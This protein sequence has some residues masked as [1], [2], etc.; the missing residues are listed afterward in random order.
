[1][2]QLSEVRDTSDELAR[3]GVVVFGVN[4][5]GAKSHEDF[6]V[7]YGYGFPLLVD[8]GGKVATAYGARMGSGTGR[9]VYLIDRDRR[10]AF[11]EKGFPPISDVLAALP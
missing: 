3:L 7:K 8:A 5:A 10:I 11:S 6:R 9:Y 2:V 1:M 4:H